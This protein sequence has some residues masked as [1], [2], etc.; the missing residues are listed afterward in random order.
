MPALAVHSSA[1]TRRSLLALGS[2][3]AVLLSTTALPRRAWG[4]DT[5]A[6]AAPQQF[7]FDLLTAEMRALAAEP[8]APPVLTPSFLDDLKYD[9]YR[10]IRFRPDRA[11]WAG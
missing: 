11:R 8:F 6:A 3:A 7:S 1:L 5:A 9:D 10:L 4:D 2:A